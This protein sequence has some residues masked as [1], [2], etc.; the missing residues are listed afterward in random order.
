[1]EV[2]VADVCIHSTSVCQPAACKA[3]GLQISEAE[4]LEVGLRCNKRSPRHA[5][6]ARASLSHRALPAL[7]LGGSKAPPDLSFSLSK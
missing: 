7:T 4:L 5:G 1:M 2:Q 3:A 6:L